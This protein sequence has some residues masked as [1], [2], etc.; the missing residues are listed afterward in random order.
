LTSGAFT[1]S[2]DN[3]VRPKAANLSMSRPELLPTFTTFGAKPT[4][5]IAITHSPVVRKAAKL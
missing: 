5:G 1:C 4:A 3:G 2:A